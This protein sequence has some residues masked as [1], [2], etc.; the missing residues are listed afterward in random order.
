MILQFRATSPVIF[1]AND[2][3]KTTT[4]PAYLPQLMLRRLH[5]PSPAT[6]SAAVWGLDEYFGRINDLRRPGFNREFD[7]PAI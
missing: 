2:H 3:A 6:G 1:L 7:R 5:G 4:N